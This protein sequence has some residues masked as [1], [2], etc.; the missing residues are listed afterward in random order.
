MHEQLRRAQDPAALG[1]DSKENPYS[2]NSDG[3]KQ[4]DIDVLVRL[5]PYYDTD[6]TLRN[7]EN[8]DAKKLR[9]LL[10]MS[11]S[12][13]DNLFKRKGISTLH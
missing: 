1:I 13:A 9:A 7:K 6:L 3:S 2:R 10:A 4:R 12:E 11:R 8:D 5:L